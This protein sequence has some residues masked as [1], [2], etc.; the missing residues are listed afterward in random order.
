MVDDVV[1]ELD[2]LKE[3]APLS[4]LNAELSRL[5]TLSGVSR[6]E[7]DAELSLESF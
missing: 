2:R 4:L 1:E 3:E 7:D 6:S 5:S